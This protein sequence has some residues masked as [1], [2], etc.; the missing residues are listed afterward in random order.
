VPRNRFRERRCTTIVFSI[1]AAV[2]PIRTGVEGLHW[3]G[4]RKAAKQ[5]PSSRAFLPGSGDNRT[6][7]QVAP[8]N[9]FLP[10]T[11]VRVGTMYP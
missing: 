6:S 3:R 1:P 2:R 7:F 8:P 9:F 11:V 5:H 10:R 4:H